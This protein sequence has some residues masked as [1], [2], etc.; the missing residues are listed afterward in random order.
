MDAAA[1]RFN[2]TLKKWNADRRGGFVTGCRTAHDQFSARNVIPPVE[3]QRVMSPP[4][5]PT[6]H[7]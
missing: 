4:A 1:A 2:G 3:A 5:A 7:R 6:A